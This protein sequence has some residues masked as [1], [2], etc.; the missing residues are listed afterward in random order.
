VVAGRR[1]C[2]RF[3]G[4]ECYAD[5]IAFTLI[6]VRFQLFLVFQFNN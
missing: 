6:G 4:T 3:A 5:A 1:F 2:G